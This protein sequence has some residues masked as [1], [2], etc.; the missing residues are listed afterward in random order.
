MDQPTVQLL[1]A[2]A[3]FTATLGGILITQHFNR[4]SESARRRYEAQSRWHEENY[5][6]SAAIVTKVAAI[7]RSLLG[8]A[9]MLDNEERDP[10]MPGTNAIELTP[11]EG[12][13]GLFDATT[14]EV[15]V[16]AVEDGLKDLDEIEDLAG[17]LEIMGS[18][19]QAAAGLL[20]VDQIHGAVTALEM[21]E[22]RWRVYQEIS[23]IRDA[24][25]AF[26]DA[27]RRNLVAV[28]ERQPT[29]SARKG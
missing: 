10:R 26:A 22:V 1:T 24:R 29:R 17:Q 21:F 25:E 15:L 14:R 8:P 9:A 4:R 18:P 7:E 27:C 20:L 3:G 6:V 2:M 13:E 23:A 5:R 12:I 28:Q 16:T 19:E 11:K